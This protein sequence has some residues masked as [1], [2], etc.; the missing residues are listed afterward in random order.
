[1]GTL[2]LVGTPIG[3]LEDITLR[4]LRVLREVSLIAAEDT[5]TTRKLLSHYD[6]HTPLTSFHDFSGPAKVRRLLERLATGDVALVSEAGMPGLSDPGYPLVT[7]AIAAGVPVT[8]VPG[9]T[10]LVSALVLSGLPTHTCHYL[11][12]LPRRPGPRRRLLA[13]VAAEPDTLVMY[14]SPHRLLA[15]LADIETVLG[16]RPMA[17]AR[18]LTKRFE[19]VIRGPVPEVRAHFTRVAPRGEFTLVVGGA[20]EAPGREPAETDMLE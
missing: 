3:N 13:R 17:A 15:A 14:E 16:P 12:F 11:G 4:A 8:T 18:E 20:P 5:R 10:A 19:E 1:M 6:I 9:P 7:A 2:Y